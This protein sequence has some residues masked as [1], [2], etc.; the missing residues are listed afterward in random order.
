M[1]TS[2]R[3][4]PSHTAVRDYTE[5]DFSLVTEEMRG[6]N[7]LKGKKYERI[8]TSSRLNSTPPM[9]APKATDTPAA[10]AADST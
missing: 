3:A 10:A 6:N 1:A 4:A 8:V 7:L 9:G 5:W 2:T